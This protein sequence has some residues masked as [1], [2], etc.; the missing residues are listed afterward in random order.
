MTLRATDLINARDLIHKYTNRQGIPN[1][2]KLC[3]QKWL[4]LLREFLHY[5]T[6]PD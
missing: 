2:G 4:R 6:C 1:T 5:M 3:C